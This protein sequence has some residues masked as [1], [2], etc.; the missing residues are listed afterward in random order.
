[1][2][3]VRKHQPDADV[4]GVMVQQMIPAGLEVIVGWKQDPQFG[5]L[6]LVGSG[7]TEVELVK[8]VAT[9]IAPLSRG[10]V[11]EMLDNTVAGRRLSG[12]R[13]APPADR[14]AVI[15]T[16]LRLSQMSLDHPEIVE[17]DINPLRVLQ[18]GGGAFAVDGRCL[19]SK[20]DFTG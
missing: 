7:G 13:G 2:D 12:W 1:M 11:K 19:L 5:P 17:L 4:Q 10:E 8:D 18:A 6:L 15:D 20:T 3:A 14:K 16:L 9:G